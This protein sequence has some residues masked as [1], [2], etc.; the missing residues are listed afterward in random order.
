MAADTTPKPAQP[1]VPLDELGAALDEEFQPLSGMPAPKASD[2]VG[3]VIGVLQNGG[4]RIFAHGA[5]RPDSIF[6]TGSV[7]KTFTGP[8][9]APMVMQHHVTLD[10]PVR[11]LLPP[12]TVARPSP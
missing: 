6:E 8:L 3:I 11:D 2:G 9:L 12:G 1:P 7:T 5:A 10:E 4:R